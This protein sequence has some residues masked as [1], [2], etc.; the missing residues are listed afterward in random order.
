MQEAD[1]NEVAKLKQSQKCLVDSAKLESLRDRLNGRDAV[2]ASEGV[3]AK[4]ALESAGNVEI[5]VR[6]MQGY[7]ELSRYPKLRTLLTDFFESEMATAAA[8]SQ[9]ITDEISGI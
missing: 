3:K 9:S 1:Y 8:K 5:F 6:G 7:F 2:G 4:P